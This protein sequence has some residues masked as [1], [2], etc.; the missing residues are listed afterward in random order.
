MEEVTSSTQ[1]RQSGE[2]KEAIP[3]LFLYKE[4]TQR[5]GLLLGGIFLLIFSDMYNFSLLRCNF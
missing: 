2:A 4:K 5:K 3:S 1:A